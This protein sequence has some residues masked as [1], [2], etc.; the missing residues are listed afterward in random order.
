MSINLSLVDGANM[1]HKEDGESFAIETTRSRRKIQDVL[2]I[3]PLKHHVFALA[4]GIQKSGAKVQLLVPL[5]CSG[6]MSTLAL[7][8]GKVGQ[9]VRGYSHL[10]LDERCI[11]S[12]LIWRVKRLTH[13]SHLN[14]FITWFDDYVSEKVR[15]GAFRARVLVTLQDYMPKTVYE[16]KRAGLLIWS[17]Q[18]LNQ[19]DETIR[20]INSHYKTENICGHYNHSEISNTEIL[21]MADVITVPSLYTLSGIA[22]RYSA[23]ARV[24]NVPYGVDSLKFSS[25]KKKRADQIRVVARANS[26]RKGGHLL[27]NSL[28]TCASR[29]L[30]LSKGKTIEFIIAGKFESDVDEIYHK[31]SLPNGFVLKSINVPH[32]KMPELLASADIFVMPSTSESMS[33][34]CIEAMQS[35]LPLIVTPYCGIDCFEPGRM[36]LE[37]QDNTASLSAG[38]IEAFERMVEW[39]SWGAAS[40]LAAENLGWDKYE[41]VISEIAQK[42]INGTLP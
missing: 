5:Y 2:V 28:H 41:Q 35:G 3:H 16:G 4:A 26:V 9:K 42:A 8:P 24:F 38:L 33:L 31:I 29:L 36:G 13:A 37:V 6:L 14:D 34:I 11:Y 21:S 1:P 10:N 40:K 18:I 15:H 30:A 27:L 20:R 19:S 7:I 22:G 12:P 25:P 23:N 17:D 32:I 39:Q